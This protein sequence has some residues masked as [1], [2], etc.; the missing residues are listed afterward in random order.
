MSPH[1]ADQLD[2]YRTGKS[3]SI[4]WTSEKIRATTVASLELLPGS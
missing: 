2:L 4:A 1:Y 3:I